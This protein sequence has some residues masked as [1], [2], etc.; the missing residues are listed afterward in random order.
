LKRFIKKENESDNNVNATKIMISNDLSCSRRAVSRW[1][2]KND[3]KFQKKAQQIMLSQK[4]KSER[5]LKILQNISRENTAFVDEKHFSLDGL[6][7]W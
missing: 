6:D 3:Y 1:L 7:I 5:I 4:H 2:K